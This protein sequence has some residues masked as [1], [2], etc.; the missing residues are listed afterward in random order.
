MDLRPGTQFHLTKPWQEKYRAAAAAL[1]FRGMAG[2]Q[3]D[4][5]SNS[6]GVGKSSLTNH[7]ALWDASTVF[8]NSMGGQVQPKPAF[9]PFALIDL[10]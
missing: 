4:I 7:L 5:I 8:A 1:N 10:D 9:L 6:A 3:I 2:R